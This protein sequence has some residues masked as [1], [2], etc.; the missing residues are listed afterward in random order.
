VHVGFQL[1]ICRVEAFSR[2][3]AV[4]RMD[5][6]DHT[7]FDVRSSSSGLP[8]V[9]SAEW[10]LDRSSTMVHHLTRHCSVSHRS[11]VAADLPLST[12]VSSSKYLV[13]DHHVPPVSFTSPGCHDSSL[14]PLVSSGKEASENGPIRDVQGPSNVDHPSLSVDLSSE[15]PSCF[16]VMCTTRAPD[17]Y[18]LRMLVFGS[19][20]SDHYF[21][22]VCWFV[23]LSVCL[24]AQSFSQPYLI[25]FR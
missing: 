5:K 3:H 9:V 22:S 6:T 11:P 15:C 16:R 12:V 19:R 17:H 10:H 13:H 21:R 24:F 18:I 14:V 2:T 1:Q 23:C 25:R 4:R 8:P 7:E 20:P